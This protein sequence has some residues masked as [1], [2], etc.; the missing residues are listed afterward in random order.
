M[1]DAEDHAAHIFPDHT[2]V[3]PHVTAAPLALQPGLILNYFLD[4]GYLTVKDWI[5][6]EHG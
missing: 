6:R 4:D 2:I 3:G 5:C 1:A